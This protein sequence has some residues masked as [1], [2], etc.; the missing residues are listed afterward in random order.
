MADWSCETALCLQIAIS[1]CLQMFSLR[2]NC[3]S[4]G[5]GGGGILFAAA[6]V[7]AAAAA[8]AALVLVFV[9]LAGHSRQRHTHER[10][11]ASLWEAGHCTACVTV[12]TS[13]EAP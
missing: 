3:V 10:F 8:A 2:K 1:C 5:G 11:V 9:V 4:D 12:S 6:A 13:M 7:A